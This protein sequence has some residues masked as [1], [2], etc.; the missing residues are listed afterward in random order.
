M[1]WEEEFQKAYSSFP[2]IIEEPVEYRIHYDKTG[3]ITMCSMRNH[4]E[5]TQYLVVD[6]ESYDNYFRYT[7]NVS[8]Q[9]LEKVALDLGISVKLKK[10]DHGYAVVK[11]H[12]GLL[13]EQHEDY[14]DVEYYDT[15]N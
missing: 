9:R 10:S 13:L 6:Q 12:A 15:P 14:I 5:N 2:K 1:N 3:K 11:N 4:P 8:R 7:V